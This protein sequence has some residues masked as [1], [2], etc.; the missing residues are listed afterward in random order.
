MVFLIIIAA[1]VVNAGGSVL[2]KY[3]MTYKATAN[4]STAMYYLLIVAAITLFGG[5]MPLYAAALGRTKLSIAQP[6]FS[7]TIYLATVLVS[8]LIL[9]EPFMPLKIVG[10]AVMM[11]GI[12]LVA[13]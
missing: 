1:G 8:L 2:L 9:R 5:G 11:S 7:A 13:S 3:A 6:I 12:A 10:I 4:P